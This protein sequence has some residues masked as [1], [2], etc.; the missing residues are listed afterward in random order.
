M[1]RERGARASRD[2]GPRDLVSW[3]SLASRAPLPT[4]V[5]LFL[6]NLLGGLGTN[7]LC[8]RF[9]WMILSP[10]G[11]W[12]SVREVF[13][14]SAWRLSDGPGEP[15]CGVCRGS[16][17]V[18]RRCLLCWRVGTSCIPYGGLVQSVLSREPGLVYGDCNMFRLLNRDICIILLVSGW[19]TFC[20]QCNLAG[21][22]VP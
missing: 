5:G 16:G 9:V 22:W 17:S 1:G 13:V 11:V 19:G 14:G 10:S 4:S 7:H 3:L 20:F 18:G 12:T 21:V 6:A 8:A 15:G 2:R